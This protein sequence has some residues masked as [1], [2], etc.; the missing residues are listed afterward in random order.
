M[1]DHEEDDRALR[2]AI[3]N[4]PS[5]QLWPARVLSTMLS[6]REFKGTLGRLFGQDWAAKTGIRVC[7]LLL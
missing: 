7:V 3:L 4:L 2:A 1:A 5:G 6:P